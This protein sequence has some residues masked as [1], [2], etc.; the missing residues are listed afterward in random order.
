VTFL[1]A[2]HDT[3]GNSMLHLLSYIGL[4]PR[5]LTKLR[6]EQAQVCVPDPGLLQEVMRNHVGRG[7]LVLRLEL[8]DLL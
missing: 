5:V 3:T 2:A 6:A 1:F 7:F 4:D 8:A